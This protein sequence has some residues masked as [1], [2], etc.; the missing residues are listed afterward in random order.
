[1]IEQ[2][3]KKRTC[4]EFENETVHL[5]QAITVISEY[6]YRLREFEMIK[7]G[8]SPFPIMSFEKVGRNDPCHVEAG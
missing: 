4:M 6:L 2:S 7:N 1:M 3:K 5:F 8:H